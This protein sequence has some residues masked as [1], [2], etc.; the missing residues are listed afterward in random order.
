MRVRHQSVKNDFV[1][2][3]QFKQKVWDEDNDD[4]VDRLEAIASDF[5]G[6]DADCILFISSLPDY[7]YSFYFER[8]SR[9]N[10]FVKA[11]EKRIG[12][13]IKVVTLLELTDNY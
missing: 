9:R 1:A 5:N 7:D 6:N 8:L 3:V 13:H 12:E 10:Q 4:V 2:L 11:I